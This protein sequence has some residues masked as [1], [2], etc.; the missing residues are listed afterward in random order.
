ME[1]PWIWRGKL[2]GYL[3]GRPHTMQY[4]LPVWFFLV[5]SAGECFDESDALSTC[6]E[7][8]E[9]FEPGLALY[10]NGEIHAFDIE[11][12][13][14]LWRYLNANWAPSPNEFRAAL[15]NTLLEAQ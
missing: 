11:D 10:A 13:S 4:P 3:S 1:Q 8:P 6:E 9:G 12:A 7:H 14:R 5:Q 15:Y 2:G